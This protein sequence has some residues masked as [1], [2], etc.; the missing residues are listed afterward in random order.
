M[1]KRSETERLPSAL[2]VIH[3]RAEHLRRFIA[4]Y[5]EFSRLP[6][7]KPSRLPWH[8]VLRSCRESYGIQVAVA[9]SLVAFVDVVQIQQVLIN[10]IKNAIEAG[11]ALKDI[12]CTVVAIEQ[13][14]LLMLD[15]RGSGMQPEVMSKALLP[16]YSTKREGTG[17]GLALAREIIEAHNG[18][19]SL[20][21][22]AGGG[23]QVRMV[24]PAG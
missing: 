16:F 14:H 2:E 3:E 19:L 17:I 15:D 13:K 1:L 4:G 7:P 12:E 21:A 10:L 9:E 8:E 20:R 18:R 22:R 6:N 11:S 5:A 24:L 23:L